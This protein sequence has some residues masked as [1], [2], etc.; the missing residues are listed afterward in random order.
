MDKRVFISFRFA[1]K[2]WRN[3]LLQ[4]FQAH[5]GPV[6]ATPAYMTEDLSSRG[7]DHIKAVIRQQMKGCVALIVLVGDDVHNS[8][9]IEWEGGVA[10][11]LQ[12]PKFGMRHPAAHGGFPNAHVGMKEIGWDMYELARIIAEL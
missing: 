10:N 7:E 8:P 12:I 11:E 3:D 6:Q 5:G 4:F 2:G 9:W 1:E